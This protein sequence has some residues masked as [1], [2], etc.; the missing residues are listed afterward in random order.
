[1]KSNNIIEINGRLYDAKTGVPL[2]KKQAPASSQPTS[3]TKKSIDGVSRSSASSSKRTIAVNHG[4]TKKLAPVAKQSHPSVTREPAHNI[5]FKAK[6]SVT[7]HRGAAKHITEPAAAPTKTVTS[8]ALKQHEATRL[9]RADTVEKS[10]AIRRFHQQTSTE[11][12]TT[13]GLK[14]HESNLAARLKTRMTSSDVQPAQ[15]TKERLI[16]QAVAKA[17]LT[18][19]RLTQHTHTASAKAHRTKRIRA[20]RSFHVARYATSALVVLVLAGYVAYLNVPGISMKVA[21][22]RA[23]FAAN[24]PG[25]KPAGYSL[26]GPIAYQPGQVTIDFRSNIDSRRFSLKQQPTSWDSVALLENYVTKQ[27]PNYLTYQDRGLTIYI[28][29]GSNASWVNGGKMYQLDG[30]NSQLDTDQLL[31][32]ATSV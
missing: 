17:A 2:D 8:S 4:A 16:S 18:D 21:S 6:Q 32:L 11:A 22:Y 1:M 14:H 26:S 13:A 20:H 23:G 15:S 30:K 9:A 5:K 27:N 29:E 28:Y 7:L 25:Y 12:Y 3:P 10:S 24:L 19:N 31:K